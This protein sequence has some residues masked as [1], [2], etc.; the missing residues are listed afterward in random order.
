MA[1][2]QAQAPVHEDEAPKTFSRATYWQ[3]L[4]ITFLGTLVVVTIANWF[5]F[6]NVHNQARQAVIGDMQLVSKE[7]QR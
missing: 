2:N 3:S 1:K 7:V 4:V 5:I 6:G